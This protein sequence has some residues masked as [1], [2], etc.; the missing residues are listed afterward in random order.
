MRESDLC[1]AGPSLVDGPAPAGRWTGVD[2]AQPRYVAVVQ[3]DLPGTRLADC[4]RSLDDIR[5][6]LPGLGLQPGFTDAGS[7]GGAGGTVLIGVSVRL[8]KGP[9]TVWRDDDDYSSR[10]GREVRCPRS[11]RTMLAKR[12]GEFP[13]FRTDALRT[14]H[15]TDVVLVL[16]SGDQGLLDRAT[17]DLAGLLDS[18]RAH[19]GGLLPEGR[20]P[21][22]F[23]D[24]VSNLQDLRARD[25][26][27]YAAHLLHDEPGVADGS[28]LV[29]RRYRAFPERLAPGAHVRIH[30]PRN[31]SARTLS[32]EQI[33]GRCRPCGAV[34][35]ATGGHVAAEYDQRQGAAAFAQSHLRKANP[36]GTGHTN[37]GHDVT[38][39]HARILRRSY[40]YAEPAAGGVEHG[41]LFLA[42]QADIQDTGFEFIHNEWLMSDFNGAPDPLLAPESGLVEPTTGC[43]YF[44]PRQQDRCSAILRGLV[45]GTAP[46][47]AGR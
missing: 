3:G 29:F 12:D 6:M 13:A 17:A 7:G 4:L 23:H 46:A 35:D 36:R 20:D 38:V 43:Y 25:P 9:F 2:T 30:D 32:A 33:V 27:A 37:F 16:E 19:R 42:F 22:G 28:Y 40:P 47:P 18:P 5:D 41:L 24:G 44:V 10:W 14:A 39:P 34:V 8:L 11:L 26:Q 15:E 1:G 21:F 45:A 31:D